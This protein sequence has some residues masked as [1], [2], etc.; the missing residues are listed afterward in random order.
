MS[1][2]RVWKEIQYDDALRY[3]ERQLEHYGIKP[4]PLLTL[5]Q[6]IQTLEN[7]LKFPDKQRQ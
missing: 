2:S 5:R 6:K 7:R 1:E 4:S 3:V